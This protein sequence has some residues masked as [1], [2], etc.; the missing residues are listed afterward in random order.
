M[1]ET[2]VDVV[3]VGG[4]PTGLSAALVLGRCRRRVLLVDSGEYRNAASHAMHGFLSRDGTD[5][6]ELRRLGRVELNRYL[7]IEVRQDQ[8]VD[9]EAVDGGFC[10]TLARGPKPVTGRRLLLATGM[11][12]E[13]PKVPGFAELYGSSAFHCPYCDGWEVADQPLVVYGQGSS[14]VGMALELTTWSRDLVLCTDGPADMSSHDAE[15][16]RRNGIGLREDRIVRLDGG[17]GMLSAV[18]FEHGEALARRALFFVTTEHQESPLAARLGCSMTRQGAVRTGPYET[19]DVPGLYVAGD[20]S[21][22][23]QAVIVA[24]AEGAEAAFAI[25]GDLLREDL[26]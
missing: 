16:L 23:V 4:G 26:R 13:L 6:A 18:V 2:T 20:A 21:R 3:V 24:A 11:V 14:G 9:A 10:V 22:S 25:N 15:K 17:G 5:P 19:T 1:S 8:V 7:T 12:D